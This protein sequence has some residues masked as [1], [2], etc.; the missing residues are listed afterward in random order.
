[1]KRIIVGGVFVSV[2]CYFET[3]SPVAQSTLELPIY[4]KIDSELLILVPPC[5][6][7]WSAGIIG[8][9]LCAQFYEVLGTDPSV[10]CV[11]DK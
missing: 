2:Y 5:L 7:I 9:C 3:E 1:M 10:L 8:P 6:N 4:V 11:I